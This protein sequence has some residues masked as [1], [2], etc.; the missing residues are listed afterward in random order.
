MTPEPFDAVVIGTGFGGAVAAC[1]L[2]Q[3][4]KTLCVL[5]RGRRY[6]LGDFPRPA[7]RP[8]SLPHT[9]RFAWAI[10]HGLWDVKDLQGLLAAVAAG[11]GGGSLVYANVH[12]RPPPQ[13]FER[14]TGHEEEVMGWPAAYTRQVL[15]PFYDVVAAALRV[16]PIPAKL[17][18]PA[19]TALIGR[20]LPKVDAMRRVATTLHR[21]QWLFLPPLA[22]DF[23][24]CVMCAECVAG[25]QVHA[26][27]TLDLN[28]LAVA[29][30]AAGVDV[31]TLAEVTGLRQEA[32]GTYTVSY[33][34]HVTGG[35]E[36][37]VRGRSVFLCAGAVNSTDIL[38][39]SQDAVGMLDES[40]KQ[41]GRRFFGNGDAISMVFDTRSGP[42]PTPTAGP[43]IATTLLYNRQ[44]GSLLATP[45][46]WFV[47]Q[48]GGYPR[49]LE[50]ALGL[51][52][53]EFW[54][55][56][57][58][59]VTGPPTAPRFDPDAA[60]DFMRQAR[61]M[62]QA[63]LGLVDARNAFQA[64]S[65]TSTLGLA[66]V[67]PR[68]IRGR[69]IP[70][71]QKF[72]HDF[73]A[74]HAGTV[75]NMT[76]DEVGDRI[77]AEHTFQGLLVPR[78]KKLARPYLLGS[79][80]EILHQYFL[81]APRDTREPFTP[82]ILWPLVVGFAQRLFLD[83]RPDDNALLMLGVGVDAAPG[84]L[85]LDD[86]GRLLASWDL[87]ANALFSSVQEQLMHD[88]AGAV[89]G[90]MRLNPDFVSRQRPVTV[91]C[92]G[93]CAMAD[94]SHDGVT[95]PDGKVWGTRA[96]YVLDGAAIP[97]SLGTNPS[98]TIAAIA[99]RNVR[100]ALADPQSPIFTP[101]EVPLDRGVP[102]WPPELT[103]AEIQR[104]LGQTPAVL[105]PIRNTPSTPSPV[106]DSAAVGFTFE[107]VMQGFY[108]RGADVNLAIRA[109]LLAT[110]DDL[111]AFL[112]NTQ[113]PV[114]IT[115]TVFLT[116]APGA[117]AVTYDA[118]GTLALLRRVDTV[119][120]VQKLFEDWMRR[121]GTPPKVAASAAASSAV[122][123]Q[124]VPDI[125]VAMDA[126]LKR[127]VKQAQRY[128]MRYD[129][130]LSGPGGPLGF[131]GVKRIYGNRGLDVWTETTTLEV[132]LTDAAQAQFGKGKMRVH[133]ADFL[134][135]QL[136]SFTV[137]G[138]RDDDD[139]RIAWAFG[140][141]FRFFFGT[142]RQVYLPQ[143]ETLNPFGDRTS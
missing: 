57:N 142:L 31:R 37:Q 128:E 112:V 61:E 15:D 26:K 7:K 89:G 30:A 131:S 134:R 103:V 59:V 143:L 47:L 72:A 45:H 66:D 133:L 111:N 101:T 74:G 35:S 140:R 14:S 1:R 43:T 53:G 44:A 58:R 38:L 3:A 141:F 48:D 8:D 116:P 71:L 86:D 56:R 92:L 129:L 21:D 18:S 42:P 114:T 10:D 33:L 109:E 100:K 137:T 25:C 124:V 122:V 5:E 123:A 106:P 125:G 81:K 40:K 6:P 39:R 67:L 49:W 95:N 138:T 19:P 130:T 22:I 99:E 4:G 108:T 12:L 107:E 27:N 24:K 60:A 78:A 135:R 68:Q 65:L 98:S 63:L 105:D 2:A 52:R 96:L 94:D 87:A 16:R 76:L 34:D 28:Y 32:D 93:G 102:S 84:Q 36:A 69:L 75:A 113:R 13:V 80:L 73:E 9:A 121:H 55:D 64:R 120:A 77:Q 104:R 79:T 11:Y 117:Q 82:E 54:L 139:A 51:F 70:T 119:V 118:K 41:I 91:H 90:E 136:P 85:F 83:R 29:E 110:I 20:P 17:A 88:V 126:L 46:E 132:V 50:P 115:G 127:L 97:T 23:E 62:G